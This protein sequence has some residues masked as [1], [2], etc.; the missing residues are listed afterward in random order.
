MLFKCWGGSVV[1]D[2]LSCFARAAAL[3][4]HALRCP[5]LNICINRDPGRWIGQLEDLGRPYF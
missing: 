1:F 4:S 2:F 3:H 5:S